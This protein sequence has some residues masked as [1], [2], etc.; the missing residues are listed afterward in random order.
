MTRR[1][2]A[3]LVPLFLLPL[4]LTGCFAKNEDASAQPPPN[5]AAADTAAVVKGNTQFAL[6]LYRRLAESDGNIF[7]SP[8]SISTALAMTYGG[9]RGE[10][11]REMADTLHFSLPPEQLHPAFAGL[12]W[13]LVGKTPHKFKLLIANRL[14]GQS[15]FTF[16]PEFLSLTE[17]NYRAPLKQVDFINAT[18]RAR[19]TINDWV[20]EQTNQWIKEPLPP[21]ILTTDTRLVLTNAIYFKAAWM[22]PFHA[23]KTKPAPFNPTTE[24]KTQRQVP[25]MHDMQRSPFLEEDTFQALVLPYEENELSMILF[26]PRKADGLAEFEKSLTA[27]SLKV[28]LKKMSLQEVT[29]AI[30][31]FKVT[32]EFQLNDRLKQMGMKLAFDPN[33]A[34]FTGMTKEDRLYI[35]QVVHKAFVDVNE[36][37][38]EAAAST[39]VVAKA[40]SRP[41]IVNFIADHP[42]LYLI[43]DNRTGSI[44]FMGRLTDPSP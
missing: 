43:R 10:T 28:W 1:D 32:A 38:T 22:R 20:E 14:W 7:F 19:N 3:T 2:F 11:A 9:A 30:P 5:V 29:M 41:R 34:D 18:E 33:K 8:Y 44:L 36:V 6:D 27:D 16:Q 23:G 40:V 42:F 12:G 4:I 31:K 21:G 24:A 15:G 17:K 35:S 13:E 25:T 26:L 39:A 37:G